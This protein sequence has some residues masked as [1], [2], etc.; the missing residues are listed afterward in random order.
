MNKEK[1]A[2][3]AND[4]DRFTKYDSVSTPRG[5][6]CRRKGAGKYIYDTYGFGS[7]NTL[8]RD[9]MNGTGPKFYK[10]NST[11]AIYVFS[12]LDEWA[13]AKLGEARASHKPEAA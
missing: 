3:K 9:A 12:D 13:L 1:V 7:S 8:A 10:P 6:G 11:D 5:P 2:E 4:G